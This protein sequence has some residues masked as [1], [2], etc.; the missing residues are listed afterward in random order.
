[1]PTQALVQ[2]PRA[3]N[4]ASNMQQYQGML[5]AAAQDYSRALRGPSA[6]QGRRRS[7]GGQ[8]ELSRSEKRDVAN[9]ARRVER[10]A[11]RESRSKTAS[12][13]VARQI[14][15]ETHEQSMSERERRQEV[16]YADPKVEAEQVQRDAKNKLDN[17]K[18]MQE[19]IAHAG[20]FLE[21]VNQDTYD[22]W[23]NWI[24]E[25]QWAPPE[26]FIPPDQV[27]QMAPEEFADYKSS[28]VSQLQGQGIGG[29][30]RGQ[31]G[32]MYAPDIKERRN[33]ETGEVIRI[34][35][36]DPEEVARAEQTGFKP[37][38]PR[39]DAFL[40][41]EGKLAATAFGTITSDAKK[42]RQSIATLKTM[43]SLLDR[44]ESGKLTNITKNLQQWGNAFGI[45]VDTTNLSAKESFLAFANQLALQSR[46]LGEGMVLA[47]QMSD[48]DVKFLKDMNPQLII[49]KGGNRMII[50]IRIALAKRRSD[51]AIDA[52]EYKKKNKGY[53]DP[54]D[55]EN[56]T[57]EKYA[58]INI[59]GIPTGAKPV[60]QDRNTGL[61]IYEYEGKYITPDL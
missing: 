46:N 5:A 17:I 42:A 16:D 40:K 19:G 14:A 58:D 27:M 37:V 48:Q 55:F 9:A 47:G 41:G 8:R 52:A 29:R 49:S 34:D 10:R 3:A 12:Q 2:A 26:V 31:G 44:F 36:R 60:G 51:V 43:E 38:G 22:D 23:V 4:P 1:M 28:L 20:T 18:R 11:E 13:N 6:P 30:G 61:P 39:S 45:P 57:R 59:F 24:S 54:L 32:R 53:F 7:S 33:A 56:Y 21:S 35:E 50:K 25:E 15:S